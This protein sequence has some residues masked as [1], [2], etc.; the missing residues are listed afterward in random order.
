MLV[1]APIVIIRATAQARR[2]V[3]FRTNGVSYT[4]KHEIRKTDRRVS[5]D[6]RASKWKSE[7]CKTFCRCPLGCFGGG[8]GFG[9]GFANQP[10]KLRGEVGGMGHNLL[11]K[12]VQRY[13]GSQGMNKFAII[14]KSKPYLAI[15]SSHISIGKYLSDC[16]TQR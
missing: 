7:I 16:R 6:I 4:K 5:E 10:V 11:M 2:A 12:F 3:C 9:F 13:F 15:K 1:G 8:R 14:V